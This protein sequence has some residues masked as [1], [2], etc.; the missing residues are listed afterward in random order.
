M[1]ITFDVS[2]VELGTV[3]FESVPAL[4]ALGRRMGRPAEASAANLRA[5]IASELNPF[6]HAAHLAFDA[7]V[8]LV[9]SPDWSLPISRR[10][11]RSSARR[12]RSC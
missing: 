7:H 5:L 4:A 10:L 3:R 9:V 8:P 12:R 2:E 11:A 6:V 1:A